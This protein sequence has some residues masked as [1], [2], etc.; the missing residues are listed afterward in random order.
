MDRGSSYLLSI[1]TFLFEIICNKQYTSDY[2]LGIID[3]KWYK[4]NPF[5][6][7]APFPYPLKTS[8]N[9]KV[10]SEV[11]SGLRKGALGTNGLNSLQKL[12]KIS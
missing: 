4:I 5:V 10:F 8:E 7:D 11:F 9:G 1:K 6:H 12:A 2:S 3:H